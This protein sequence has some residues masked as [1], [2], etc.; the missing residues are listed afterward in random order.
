MG[1]DIQNTH[2]QRNS[3][4]VKGF[5]KHGRPCTA[6]I[7]CLNHDIFRHNKRI[8]E[9][10]YH[11]PYIDAILN[12]AQH[13]SWFWWAYRPPCMCIPSVHSTRYASRPETLSILGKAG[14]TVVYLPSW[15]HVNSVCKL[16]MQPYYAQF[17]AG[18]RHAF[19]SVQHFTK[20]FP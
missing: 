8:R 2:F 6:C 16:L 3:I 13:D 19:S 14:S 12:L 18:G 20:L 5:S 11:C 15:I 17:C 4:E 7:A 9:N 1:G 10:T